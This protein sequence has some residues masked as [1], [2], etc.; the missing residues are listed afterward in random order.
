MLTMREKQ[1]NNTSGYRG[2]Y[3]SGDKWIARTAINN[4]RY[5]LGSFNSKLEANVAVEEKRKLVIASIV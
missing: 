3:K 1:Y 2:V 5:Y 4:N